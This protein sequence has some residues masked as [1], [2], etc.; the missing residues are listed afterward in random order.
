[1]VGVFFLF[2][3]GCRGVWEGAEE[4]RGGVFFS[5][6]PPPKSQS[7][8]PLSTP[9]PPPPFPFFVFPTFLSR[10]DHFFLET[11]AFFFP[12]W[13]VFPPPRR[14]GST[15]F[16]IVLYWLLPRSQ[17]YEAEN[18]E[19]PLHPPPGDPGCFFSPLFDPKLHLLPSPFF[20]SSGFHT[21]SW[22][23]CFVPQMNLDI[24]VSL[25]SLFSV[26]STPFPDSPRELFFQRKRSD[27]PLRPNIWA[28]PHEK[29]EQL[30]SLF[31]SHG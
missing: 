13:L 25:V 20:K 12:I 4:G 1:L 24:S 5:F 23:R 16:F 31:L 11:A 19:G 6:G 22:Y 26:F 18:S 10:C 2:C 27:T 8:I 21:L 28:F 29:F 3:F 7:Y 15:S 9:P 17:Q 30:T 14:N